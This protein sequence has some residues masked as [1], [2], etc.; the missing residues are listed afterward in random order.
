MSIRAHLVRG[1]FGSL[2]LTIAT[3][4][5]TFINGVLLARLLGATGY[6]IYA[7]AIAVVLLLSLPLTLG[8]DRLLIRD[9]AASEPR[10]AW[11]Q[12][13]GLINRSV[14]VVLPVSILSIIIVGVGALLLNGSLENETLPVLWL[15]L[16]MIPLLVLTALRRS[17]SLG[18]QRIVSSQLPDLVVR[19]GLFAILLVIAF[20]VVGSLSATAA[21]GLNLLSVAVAFGAGMYLLWREIPASLRRAQPQFHTRRWIREALPF[22]LAT[23]ALTIMNQIDV[24]LVGSL[25]GATAAGLYAVAARGAGL[26][27]F[28]ALAVSTTL[29]PTASR[30]WTQK[31]Y[32]RLQYVVTRAA[33]GA[34]LF[35]LGVAVVLW[36]FGTQ[37]L[38]IF[39]PEFAAANTTMAVLAL[40]QVI[41]CG[42]GIGSLMLTMTGFQTVNFA[43]VAVAVV[44]RVGLDVVLIPGMG[45]LGAAV[46]AV[47]SVTIFNAFTAWFA[48]R[49][50]HID[51]TPVGARFAQ[52]AA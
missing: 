34:F 51:P 10:D 17:I 24:V 29:A 49:R 38:L 8:F 15:A 36:L 13:R 37:F 4:G 50:L 26:A 6:G 14:Q 41:D 18:L 21:M 40:A 52:S 42:F 19:P 30:L 16:L 1:V 25:A 44:F 39:G 32:A 43:S 27:L 5:L 23:T 31:E 35:A 28:G 46:A 3:A 48:W 12:A 11:S 2:G 9:V 47:V 45:A 33:R 20:L 22:A 7:S